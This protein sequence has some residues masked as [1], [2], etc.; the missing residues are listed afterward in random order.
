MVVVLMI[1]NGSCHCFDA[2]FL[3][4]H[5]KTKMPPAGRVGLPADEIR[6]HIRVA[7]GQKRQECFLRWGCKSTDTMK[8]R[9]PFKLII[10]LLILAGIGL[11]VWYF[12]KK[13]DRNPVSGLKPRVEMSV[14]RIS[15]ITDSTLK[16]E[17]KTLV[18]NPLPVGMRLKALHY[19]VQMNGRTVV[20]DRYGEP[21]E[22]KAADSSVLTLPAKVK[23]RNL[24]MEGDEEAAKGEDSADYHFQTVLHFEKAFLG[25]DSLVL[26]M[27]KRLPLYRL[28]MMKMAG[29]DFKK[30]GLKES[31]IVVKVEVTNLNPFSLEF[32]NPTY[33][34]DL[35][36]Q[37]RFAEGAV[38]GITK[39]KSKSK[40]VYEIPL[41]V[42][43]GKV[44]KA[45]AQMIGQG[46]ELPFTFYFKSKIKSESD[47]LDNSDINLVMNGELKDI[48]TFQQNLQ[49]K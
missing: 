30:L 14:G 7:A 32:Q 34:M 39:V 49:R 3:K 45:G 22:V 36:K 29:Y 33:A 31:D 35:G 46:K 27:D 5:T 48:E 16:M 4:I 9:K 8:Q 26:E 2:P 40:D 47:V 38:T 42:S 17:L 24:R 37:K 20:E 18:H 12:F 11:G 1:A 21:L 44:I 28:P 41:S 25:K 6:T 10:I 13:S 19:M 23:I 43:L 15:D